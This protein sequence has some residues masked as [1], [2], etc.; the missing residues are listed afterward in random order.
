M[1]LFCNLDK[2]IGGLS[3][4]VCIAIITPYSQQVALLRQIFAQKFGK[5]YS[6]KVEISTVDAFQGREASI[7]IF[8]CVRAAHK[9][10]G[11]GF[12]SDVKRMNVALTRAKHFLFVITRCRTIIV[13]PYWRD[14]VRHAREQRAIIKV[15]MKRGNKNEELSF[16]GLK[17]L[18]PLHDST[19]PQLSRLRD[20][21]DS[22]GEFSA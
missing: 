18:A 11:I 3:S 16:P 7:V 6:T 20:G 19:Q 10:V 4:E 9:G 12:L 22:E 21:Y 1:E 8:S 14:L 15:P 5:P 17:T 13:N 2:D